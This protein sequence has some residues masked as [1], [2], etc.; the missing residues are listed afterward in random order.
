M[1][2]ALAVAVA[3]AQVKAIRL[4]YSQPTAA[5]VLECFDGS[6][7]AIETATPTLINE[8]A[9]RRPVSAVKADD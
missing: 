8:A 5:V 4:D 9:I 7:V 6:E 1:A 2:Q 3:L